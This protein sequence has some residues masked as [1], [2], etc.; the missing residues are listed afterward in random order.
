RA[1]VQLMQAKEE[2]LLA[3]R[4]EAVSNARATAL[5]TAGGTALIAVAL[6]LL[7]MFL[8]SRA[9]GRLRRSEQWLATTLGSIGDAVIATDERGC[10]KY[11]NPVAEQLTGWSSADARAKRLEEVFN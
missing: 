11:L 3:S 8:D 7:V 10:V 6:V 2:S 4:L 9:S 5:L 1:Q